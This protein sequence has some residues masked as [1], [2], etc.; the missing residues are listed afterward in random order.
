[1]KAGRMTIEGEDIRRIVDILMSRRRISYKYTAKD[2]VVLMEEEYYARVESELLSVYI[3]NFKDNRT[4]NIELAAG[5]GKGEF[6]FDLGAEETENK[7][8]AQEIIEICKENSWNITDV[9]PEEFKKSLEKSAARLFME[10][11]FTWLK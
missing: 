8:N 6:A 11:I 4:V 3:L 9:E 10:S 1:M 7:Q 2:I 5:G